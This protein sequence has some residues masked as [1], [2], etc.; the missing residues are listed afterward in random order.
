LAPI[1]REHKGTHAN[2]LKQAHRDG[3]TRARVDGEV[4]DLL[5]ERAVPSL[6]KTRSHTVELIVDR[7]MSLPLAFIRGTITR[8]STPYAGCGTPVTPSWSSSTTPTRC[9]PP[10]G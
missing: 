2:V 10:T 9:A 8:C 3:Y 6:E 4:V 7:L 1:V 5:S